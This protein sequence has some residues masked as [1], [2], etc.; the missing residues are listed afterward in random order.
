MECTPQVG[1]AAAPQ[2]PVVAREAAGD[3]LVQDMSAPGARRGSH[4]R[5]HSEE[6]CAASSAAPGSATESTEDTADR[7]Q[8]S[9][10]GHHRRLHLVTGAH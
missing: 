9:P 1:A 10:T 7:R 2:P 5:R 4:V 6:L 8:S 3:G